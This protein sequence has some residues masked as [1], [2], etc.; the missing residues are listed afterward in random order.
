[1]IFKV[2]TYG[3]QT[4]VHPQFEGDLYFQQGFLQLRILNEGGFYSRVATVQRNMVFHINT[5]IQWKKNCNSC[6]HKMYLKIDI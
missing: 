3:E 6:D 1:M 2:R 5:Y 4:V